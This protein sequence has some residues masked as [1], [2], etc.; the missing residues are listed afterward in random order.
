[1]EKTTTNKSINKVPEINFQTVQVSFPH[2]QQA[3]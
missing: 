2:F 1:M 3:D